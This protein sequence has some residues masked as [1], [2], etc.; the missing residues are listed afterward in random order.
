SALQHARDIG[1]PASSLQPILQQEKHLSSTSAPFNLFDDQ[2]ATNYYLGQAKQYKQL[3]TQLQGIVDSTTSDAMTKAQLSL[4]YFQAALT[5]VQ[6][7][8]A[9][10]TQAFLQEYNTDQSQLSAAQ[11]PKQFFAISND[12]NNAASALS[13]LYSTYEQLVTFNNAIDQMNKAHLDV[14]AM[15]SQYQNDLKTLNTITKTADFSKLNALINAQY[16]MAVV[17]SIQALPF[18]GNAKLNQF[19]S[20]IGL[21]KTYGM[22]ASPYQQLYNTDAQQM[23]IAKTIQDYLHTSQKIDADIAS[24]QNDLVQGAASYMI[25]E[26]D[27]EANA[28]GQAH[29]YHDKFD[30]NNYILDSGYTM[31]GIG[32]WLQEQLSWAWQPA[33]YQAL[34]NEENDELFDLRMMEQDYSDPTPY[35]QVHATD[36]E[37]MQHY[38][39]LQHG[40]V[41]MVSMVEQAMRF[42]QDGKLVRS[43][44][45]TMGR[46]ERPA[47]PGYW[48]VVDRKSPTQFTSS[49]P[50][51]SPFWYPPTPIHYAILYHWDGYF[52]HDAWWRV[53]FGPGTQFPHYDAGGD[54]SFAG[55]GSHGCI[56]MQENDAAWVYA[57]TDWNTQI[58]VY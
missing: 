8:K 11:D 57:N 40:K 18:V 16:Q 55:N 27:R 9:G 36:M 7:L 31:N 37:I 30:G 39:S 21:L 29:L 43:F 28:W 45:V 32:Y 12:A 19:Q 52:V 14:A 35:N 49:D 26:L 41:L 48:T 6:K 38:P 51:S 50:P 23:H 34:V 44:Y 10:N 42:Y 33:D 5:K 47:L 46:V 20:Q 2:P 22:N 24:M 53:N 15:E 54:E 13:L 1:V 58:M 56:N 3:L 25:G 4:Q 17:N